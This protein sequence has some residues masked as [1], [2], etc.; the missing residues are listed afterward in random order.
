MKTQESLI[1]AGVFR[2]HSIVEQARA[3]LRHAGFRS[4]QARLS[5]GA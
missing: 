3:E 4:D 1:V 5:Q 2:D